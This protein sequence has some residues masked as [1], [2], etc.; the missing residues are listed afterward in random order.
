MPPADAPSVKVVKMK[1]TT[2]SV[3]P[4]VIKFI[5]TYGD[6]CCAIQEKYGLP[7]LAVAAQ[8]A[9]ETGWGKNV[10]RVTVNGVCICSNNIFNIKAGTSWTGKKGSVRVNEFINGKEIYED[11]FF[12]VYDTAQESFDG[13]ADYILHRLMP[14][15]V[16]LRYAKAIAAK[17]DPVK[18]IEAVHAAGYATDPT[19]A[20]QCKMIFQKYFIL[21]EI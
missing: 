1:L 15:G 8:A 5:A 3:L 13:Y 4:N 7:A 12:R 16:T 6:A 11:A 19:Y 18:Y 20:A 9:L 10:L 14:D 17:D 2:A 21:S